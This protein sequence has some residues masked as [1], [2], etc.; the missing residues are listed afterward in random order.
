[1]GDGR[2][3]GLERGI[4]QGL[5]RLHSEEDKPEG[6]PR[7]SDTPMP[8]DNNTLSRKDSC[9]PFGRA[10]FE[11]RNTFLFVHPL[12]SFNKHSYN[13][14]CWNTQKR[15]LLRC[16]HGHSEIRES[17]ALK[18]SHAHFLC[19]CLK[20]TFCSASF[21]STTIGRYADACQDT[22]TLALRKFFEGDVKA[23]RHTCFAVWRRVVEEKR[24]ETSISNEKA[25]YQKELDAE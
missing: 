20:N 19:D 21:E 23:L 17:E 22:V 14:A 24:T 6:A 4:L 11:V 5:G 1:M 8:Q 12:Q 25:Q 15:R 18:I 3:E 2:V 13:V 10:D 7:K 16:S 9:S